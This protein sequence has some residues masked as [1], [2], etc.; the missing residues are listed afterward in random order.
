MCPLLH[1]FS[2]C[3]NLIREIAAASYDTT[4]VE[5]VAKVNDDAIDA[6]RYAVMA[7]GG[8]AT[9]FVPQDGNQRREALDGTPLHQPFGPYAK[10]PEDDEP[11]WFIPG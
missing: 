8:Q 7:I 4:R 6:L 11:Q 3:A 2:P 5:D 1:V 10:P 9:F